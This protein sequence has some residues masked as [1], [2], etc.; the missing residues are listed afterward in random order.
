MLKNVDECGAWA[1]LEMTG[2]GLE[3]SLEARHRCESSA[4]AC[5]VWHAVPGGLSCG[6]ATSVPV[7][8][9]AEVWFSCES[10]H[11]LLQRHCQAR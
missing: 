3:A 6:L 5:A 1:A 9:P 11:G 8:G 2:G 7:D 10:G 4:G